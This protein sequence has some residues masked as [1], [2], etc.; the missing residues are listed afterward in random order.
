[1]I[2]EDLIQH[3]QIAADGNQFRKAISIDND[4]IL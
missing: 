3:I 2:L 1:M 4:E